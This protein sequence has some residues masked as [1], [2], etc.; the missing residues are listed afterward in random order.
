MLT[1]NKTKKEKNLMNNIPKEIIK[2]IEERNS[3]SLPQFDGLSPIEMQNLLYRIFEDGC[4]VELNKLSPSEYLEVPILNEAKYILKIIEDS[5]ELKLTPRGNLPTK[6]VADIYNQ[7]FIK[8]DHIE[9]GIVKLRTERDSLS[10]TVTRL[11]LEIAG[12]IKKR[13]N[14]LS[15]TKKGSKIFNDDHK[16]LKA[17]FITFGTKFNWGYFDGY[18]DNIVG[19][20]GFGFTIHLLSRYGDKL[21]LCS[22]YSDKYFT[23]FPDLLNLLE[24]SLYRPIEEI[25]LDCYTT[26]T[27]ERFLNY[28][29]V[30]DLQSRRRLDDNSKVVKTELFDRLFKINLPKDQITLI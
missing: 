12:I 1:K 25:A 28:F 24:P 2:E 26:R 4:P 8:E 21:E 9:A 27:F 18:G 20:Q 15:L 5:E 22:L 14:K 3:T 19:Q 16:L 13:N 7:G 23:A 10:I 29:G 30:V 17:I 11:I 6:I